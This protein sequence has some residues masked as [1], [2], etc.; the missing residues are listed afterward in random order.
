VIPEDLYSDPLGQGMRHLQQAALVAPDDVRRAW[1]SVQAAQE[2]Q[3]N[4]PSPTLRTLVSLASARLCLAGGDKFHA[5][6]SLIVASEACAA[7][8]DQDLSAQLI[9]QVAVLAQESG[10]NR[11]SRVAASRRLAADESR[12]QRAPSWLPSLATS[13]TWLGDLDMTDGDRVGAQTH[14]QA[15]L[16]IRQNLVDDIHTKIARLDDL[17]P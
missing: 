10:N 4:H 9:A 16:L 15:A 8:T 14:H 13:H 5:S 17:A 7:I 1:R 11:L 3:A 2:V 6:A 12:A